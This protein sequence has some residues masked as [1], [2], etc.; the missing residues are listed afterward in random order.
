M[1]LHKASSWE[2]HSNLYLE[3]VDMS[4][5]Y[6]LLYKT[7]FFFSF[8]LMHYLYHMLIYYNGY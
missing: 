5:N 4:Q 3:T 7:A 8:L 1:H 6:V 2:N